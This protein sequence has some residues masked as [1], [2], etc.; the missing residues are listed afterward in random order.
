MTFSRFMPL[1][2]GRIASALVADARSDQTVSRQAETATS[3][4]VAAAVAFLAS[5]DAAWITAHILPV[6][7]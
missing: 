1:L 3:E 2:P 7:G 6:D 4:D 5:T